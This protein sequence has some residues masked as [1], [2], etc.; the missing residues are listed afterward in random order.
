MDAGGSKFV[1][2]TFSPSKDMSN[3]IVMADTT[4][5]PVL[6]LQCSLYCCTCS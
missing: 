6:S 5:S 2:I 1:K 4:V 3:S